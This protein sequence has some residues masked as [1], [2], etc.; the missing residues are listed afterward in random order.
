MRKSIA[1]ISIIL[2]N[3]SCINAQAPGTITDIDGNVYRTVTIGRFVWMAENLRVTKYNNGMMIPIVTNDTMWAELKS[4][5]YCWYDNNEDNRNTYG[6]LYNW[7]TVST[8]DLCPVGWRV[9]TDEEWK[10][11]EGYADS[12]YKIGNL[13][14]DKAGLREYNAGKRL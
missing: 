11:L 4:G 13:I 8:G 12:V 7:Y 5:A 1:L 6:A 9:P 14:W 10:Y 3:I 2:F